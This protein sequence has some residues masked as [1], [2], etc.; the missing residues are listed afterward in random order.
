M[1][2]SIFRRDPTSR[3]VVD[4]ALRDHDGVDC[5]YGGKSLCFLPLSIDGER[6][7]AAV[8]RV[9]RNAG[10]RARRT[11]NVRSIH[12]A[13][14]SRLECFPAQ[15]QELRRAAR[16][17]LPVDVEYLD[18]SGAEVTAQLRP[19]IEEQGDFFVAGNR[20]IR[21]KWISGVSV[22]DEADL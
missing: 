1:A 6:V 16:D 8:P 10:S 20:R 15:L 11:L 18:E 13:S 21:T 17:G 12:W 4:R 7:L 19:P 5:E 22:N 9:W 14:I 3:E 2:A